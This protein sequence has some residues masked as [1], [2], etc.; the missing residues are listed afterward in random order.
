MIAPLWVGEK[1]WGV[2]NVEELEAGAFDEDD[3][4]LLETVSDQVGAALR[5]A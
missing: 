4:R 2:L 3:L 5:S 1:L